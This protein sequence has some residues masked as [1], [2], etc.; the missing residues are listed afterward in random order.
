MQPAGQCQAVNSS[1]N[2]YFNKSQ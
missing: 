1:P 2:I